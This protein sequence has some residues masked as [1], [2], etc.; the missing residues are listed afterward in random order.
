MIV[1][2]FFIVKMIAFNLCG[3]TVL[4]EFMFKF[5]EILVWNLNKWRNLMKT[6]YNV[7][8]LYHS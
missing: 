7:T 4:A 3:E 2:L 8:S 6:A 1:R 5:L